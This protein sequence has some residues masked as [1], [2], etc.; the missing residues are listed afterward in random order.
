MTKNQESRAMFIA[1]LEN[2]NNNGHHW[3]TIQAVLA[4][5]NDCDMLAADS[6]DEYSLNE[7][8]H[9]CMCAEIPDSQLESII[10]ELERNKNVQV[11]S[12]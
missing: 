9:A 11:S 3:L 5:L 4:L 1:R 8:A 10:I 7:I 12:T 2:M 6:E